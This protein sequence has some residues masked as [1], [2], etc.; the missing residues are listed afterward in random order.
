MSLIDFHDLAAEHS[1][2]Q[3]TCQKFFQETVVHHHFP[4][5]A[6]NFSLESVTVNLADIISR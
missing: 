4:A 6:Q 1:T 5:S 2:G 3:R